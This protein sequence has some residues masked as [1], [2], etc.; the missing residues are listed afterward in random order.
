MSALDP[1]GIPIA[2]SMVCPFCGGAV[3]FVDS[4]KV[5][6]GRSYGMAYV[7]SN[8]PECDAYVGTHPGTARPLGTLA[9]SNT[10][11]WRRRAH[12]WL[13]QLWQGGEMTRTEVY[14]ALAKYFSAPEI[15]VGQSDAERCR[16]IIAFA[17]LYLDAS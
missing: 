1:V 2:E 6:H 11:L 17:K 3:E 15:H 16:Q 8:W 5:Y 10:R 4:A 7:C 14:T 9:D 12:S 13:D